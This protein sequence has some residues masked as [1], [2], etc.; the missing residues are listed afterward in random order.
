[1]PTYDNKH[2]VFVLYQQLTYA[3]IDKRIDDAAKLADQLVAQLLGDFDWSLLDSSG[4]SHEVTVVTAPQTTLV[5]TIK[6]GEQDV[7]VIDFRFRD[8]AFVCQ[9]R[10]LEQRYTDVD[11]Y[12]QNLRTILE[13]LLTGSNLYGVSLV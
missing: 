8:C 11:R 9:R 12:G 3:G 4:F 2:P 1:M 7:A 13:R 6:D 10:A 5:V